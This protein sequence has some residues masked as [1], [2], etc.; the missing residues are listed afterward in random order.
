LAVLGR[1]AAGPVDVDALA[2]ELGE[3]PRKV[4]KEV[5]GLREAGLMTEAME[6]DRDALRS[7]AAALPRADSVD[8]A[9]LAGSW[10]DEEGVVLARFLSGTRPM[11][12]SSSRGKRRLGVC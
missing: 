9:V 12:I 1:A 4:L 8:P 7:I 5:G 6:L 3:H 2:A 11:R 10:S